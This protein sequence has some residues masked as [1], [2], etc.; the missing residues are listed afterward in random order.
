MKGW[1]RNWDVL[2]PFFKYTQ[3]LRKI[4]Y[5]TNTIESLNSSYR[6]LNKNRTVFPSDQSL[7]K[8]I[9]LATQKITKK[10]TS[11]YHNWGLILG[12]L[13][14]MFEGRI[15]HNFN[16]I[17]VCEILTRKEFFYQKFWGM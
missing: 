7:M 8:S 15:I 5:T 11:I 1:E 2:S 12:Q 17:C 6:R 13:E 10:W 14:I 16:A 9:Y 4:I 3:E